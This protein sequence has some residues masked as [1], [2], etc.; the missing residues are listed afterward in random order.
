MACVRPRW[1]GYGAGA[2]AVGSAAARTYPVAMLRPGRPEN[3][4]VIIV[5]SGS[6]RPIASAQA[7]GTLASGHR[8]NAVPIWTADAPNR[9]AAATP[10]P[11]PIPPDATTGSFT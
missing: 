10:R 6:V 9:G 2:G 3:H 4:R 5:S 11:S 7:A 8:S 1:I